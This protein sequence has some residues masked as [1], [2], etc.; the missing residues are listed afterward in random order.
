MFK[1]GWVGKI[2]IKKRKCWSEFL[3]AKAVLKSLL[4]GQAENG[5]CNNKTLRNDP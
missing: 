1:S 5:K 3:K 4:E 2:A